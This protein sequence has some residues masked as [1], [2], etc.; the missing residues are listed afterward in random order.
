[1]LVEADADG[2]VYGSIP[3]LAH[4]AR[5]SLADCETAL[6]E[7]QQADHYSRD[8][9]NDGRRIEEIDGGW[10]IINYR[11]WRMKA[12]QQDRLEKQRERQ[13]RYRERKQAIDYTEEFAD[14]TRC[15]ESYDRQRQRQKQKQI[16]ENDPKKGHSSSAKPDGCPHQAIIELFHEVC[17]ML[18][19]V[20]QWT[21]ARQ[22]NLR[23]RW[24]EER[25]RQNL[26]WWRQFFTVVAASDFLCG[27]V[28]CKD[29]KPFVA[30]LP[31]LVKAE[32][33]SKVLEGN[34]DND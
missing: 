8:P 19:Q 31:W 5:V 2:E 16:E 32:N 6:N 3:G 23:Q 11:K 20:R 14:V 7:F 29:R 30:S 27:R 24:R 26:D 25:K 33:F 34:Y 12:S 18:T 28:S 17:P 21:P 9:E 4:I 22:A 13:K 1:M 15:D 10:R